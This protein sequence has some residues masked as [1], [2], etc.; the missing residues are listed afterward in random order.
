MNCSRGQV[1]ALAAISLFATAG[2]GLANAGA[3]RTAI[4]TIGKLLTNCNSPKYCEEWKNAGTGAGAIGRSRGPG[5]YGVTDA[6]NA[7]DGAGVRGIANAGGRGVEG[8][9]QTS[10]G[11]LGIAQSYYGVRGETFNTKSNLTDA[12][13]EGLDGNT[14]LTST[15][16][17]VIGMTANSGV[18][19]LGNSQTTSAQTAAAGVQGLSHVTNPPSGAASNAALSGISLGGEGL[20]AFSQTGGGAFFESAAPSIAT[21]DIHADASNGFPL[22]SRNEVTGDHVDFDSQGDVLA[23]G[24]FQGGGSEISH[25][26]TDGH[27][28]LTYGAEAPEVTLEDAGTGQ[29]TGGQGFVAIESRFASTIDARAYHVFLTPLGD[30]ALYV[31]G[32][33]AAGFTVRQIGGGHASLAFDYRIV[34]RPADSHASRLPAATNKLAGLTVRPSSARE[35]MAALHRADLM[36][37]APSEARRGSTGR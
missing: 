7:V 10:E 23:S 24:V 37:S 5:L 1:G 33:G 11:V 12:G 28:V 27:R 9:S 25:R 32:K 6:T 20:Y 16:A 34:A 2:V 3:A 29:L 18:G 26:T 31:A 21:L 14:N 30:A 8:D 19:V 13:V 22:V 36:E 35:A 15:N 4:G 17:G